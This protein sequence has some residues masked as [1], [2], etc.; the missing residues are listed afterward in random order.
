MKKKIFFGTI[1]IL[2]L[3]TIIYVIYI[4][5]NPKI[6]V[7]C[8]HNIGTPEEKSNFPSEEEWTIDV[9]NFEEHLKMLKNNNYKTLKLEEFYNWKQGKNK[10]PYKSVLITFDD[11]FL[12]NY[13]YAFPLLKKYN[14]NATVFL[15]GNYIPDTNEKWNGNLK[16]YMSKKTIE[17]VAEEYPN[18]DFASH[19]YSLHEPGILKNKNY[20]ELLQDGKA[21]KEKVLK[22]DIYC[23]P[24]GAY[25]DDMIN[26]L[27]DNK[28]KMA[29]IFGPSKKEYRKASI[30]DDDFLVPR[31]NVSYGMNSKKFLIRLLLPY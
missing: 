9:S 20:E 19:S 6:A 23:Y 12:S 25:N 17:K 22:T 24:F 8:Y 26:A 2:V 7:L 21:F 14:M 5:N 27:K 4:I 3:I 16:T 15:I 10:L 1:I 28:Y 18:I 30:K 13:E 31:L 11:G 29:F